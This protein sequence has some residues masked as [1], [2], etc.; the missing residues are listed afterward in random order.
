VPTRTAA[1]IQPGDTVVDKAT[2]ATAVVLP[3]GLTRSNKHA[4]GK[5]SILARK[6]CGRVV[7]I[8]VNDTD[9]LTIT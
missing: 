8:T 6:S 9:R 5:V 2:G 3:N 7:R 1:A 4:P